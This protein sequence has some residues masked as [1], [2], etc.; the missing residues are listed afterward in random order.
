MIAFYFLENL[1][2]VTILAKVNEVAGNLKS[3]DQQKPIHLFYSP[4]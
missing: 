2:V 3:V 1:V 4:T